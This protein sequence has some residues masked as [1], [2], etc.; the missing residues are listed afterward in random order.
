M[1]VYYNFWESM[2]RAGFMSSSSSEA[3]K[4]SEYNT[5]VNFV[6][7]EIKVFFKFRFKHIA[8]CVLCVTRA[9]KGK[10]TKIKWI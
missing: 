4:A 5:K 3:I 9:L 1:G 2:I 10:Y 6:R 7:S 8:G